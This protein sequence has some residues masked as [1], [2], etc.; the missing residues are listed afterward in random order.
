MGILLV[1]VVVAFLSCAV[2]NHFWSTLGLCVILIMP[3]LVLLSRLMLCSRAMSVQTWLNDYDV[4]L[5]IEWFPLT[6]SL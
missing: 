6:N 5:L 3:P 1:A 2:K 4:D